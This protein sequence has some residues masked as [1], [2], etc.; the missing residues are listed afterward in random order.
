MAKFAAVTC[1]DGNFLVREQYDNKDAALI[2]FD[3]IHAALVND[4]TMEK[5]TIKILDDQLNV[6]DGKWQDTIVHEVTKKTTKKE[7]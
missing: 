3:G 1:T 6:L 4:K 7:G 2:G 5:G